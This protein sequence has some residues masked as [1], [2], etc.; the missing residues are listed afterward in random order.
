MRKEDKVKLELIK[1]KHRRE[2]L[3]KIAHK[4]MKNSVYGR[5]GQFPLRP[6]IKNK[7]TG[8]EQ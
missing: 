8:D 3:V 1:Q 6:V 5:F 2:N 4:L 7:I